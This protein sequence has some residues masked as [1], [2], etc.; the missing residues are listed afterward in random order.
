M[1]VIK[2][3][4]RIKIFREEKAELAML[5]AKT[6]LLH[7]EEA[8]DNARKVLRKHK[9]DCIAREKELY[10]DLCTR[11]VLLKDIN[12][13]TLDVQL[14]AEE[15][16]RLDEDVEKYKEARDVASEDLAAAKAVHRDAVQMRQKF[17]EVK[18]VIDAEKLAELMRK[19]D[20][21]MEEVPTKRQFE[22]EDPGEMLEIY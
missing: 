10:D 12:S 17:M 3:L 1:E 18:D 19:E 11:L 15:T 8:L 6:K 16:T 4:V 14:M 22:T 7:A 9:E 5:K 20:L 2:D 21:E 13:V